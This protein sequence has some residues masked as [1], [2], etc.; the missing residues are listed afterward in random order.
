MS[1]QVTMNADPENLP[2]G[3]DPTAGTVLVVEPQPTYEPIPGGLADM[4]P[5]PVM[6]ALLSSIN[7]SEVSGHD[8]VIVLAAHDRMAS[9]HAAGR[10]RAMAAVHTTMLNFDGYTQL[11]PY[12]DSSIRPR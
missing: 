10:Y 4:E 11:L 3:C 6:G 7:V 1:D 9:H 2:F 12:D 8:Q 5:G